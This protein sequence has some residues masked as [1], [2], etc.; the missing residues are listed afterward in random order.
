LLAVLL[1]AC[2]TAQTAE[3]ESV[4][5]D[6]LE[7]ITAL[8][9]EIGVAIGA[10]GE[11]DENEAQT[12]GGVEALIGL[13]NAAAALEMEAATAL[14]RLNEMDVPGKCRQFHD[15][16]TAAMAEFEQMGAEYAQGADIFGQD[17]GDELIDVAALE[18]GDARLM[19]AQQ[20]LTEAAGGPSDECSE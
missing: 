2:G 10:L 5:E 16:V 13:R 15:L 17:R 18:R 1:S 7:P 19:A 12:A 3:Y 4:V 6:I 11:L 8:N 9:A 14:E 20:K